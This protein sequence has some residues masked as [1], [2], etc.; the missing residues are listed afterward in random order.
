LIPSDTYELSLEDVKQNSE[1]YHVEEVGNLISDELPG[2]DARYID[3][4]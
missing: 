4:K 1:D 3:W 2:A